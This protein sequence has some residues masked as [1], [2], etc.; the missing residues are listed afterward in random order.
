[1]QNNTGND[2][3]IY[4]QM[5]MKKGSFSQSENGDFIFDV[6]AS[7]ENLD[8]EQQKVLQEALLASKD[9]FLKNGVISKDHLHQKI[10]EDGAGK[11]I[12]FDES[13]VIG[14]PIAVYTDGGST[15][16]R[17]KLYRSNPYA[18]KFIQLLKDGSSRIKASVGGI[19][20]LVEKVKE[21]GAEIGKIVSVLWNDLALTIAPV[22]PTVSAASMV[23]SLSSLEFVK[24][25][26][27]GAGTDS[28]QYT[29]GRAMV[30]E[31]MQG[32][33]DDAAPINAFIQAVLAGKIQK[34]EDVYTFLSGFGIEGGE[35]EEA[36]RSIFNDKDIREVLPMGKV[37]LWDNMKAQLEKSFGGKK[38]DEK[39]EEEEKKKKTVE[40]SI[41]E[42][43][44]KVNDEKE[45]DDEADDE[46][47]N[48]ELK[49]AL[50][51][52]PLLESIAGELEELKNSVS[53]LSKSIASLSQDVTSV[54]EAAEKAEAQQE[55]L[56]KSLL[57]IADRVQSFGD[58]PVP[59]GAAV[60]ALEM[61]K[62]QGGD[63]AFVRHKQFTQ[64]AKKDALEVLLKAASAGE[65]SAI[66]LGKAESQ[67]N[68]SIRDPSFQ[69]DQKY[70]M[71]LQKAAAA[72]AV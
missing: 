25:L 24:S 9:Y 30:P 50:D 4:L 33:R 49:K 71:L 14:E 19:A 17:G 1:M 34:E 20:P 18:Q 60:R 39:E 38:K 28:A 68:K 11:H 53:K 67:I 12:I 47:S 56:G 35:A 51:A 3:M 52:T 61:R 36:I 32:K 40:K 54:Q 26:S 29:G 65:I 31:D 57:T 2:R 37:N 69:L 23:K 13:F 64:E 63:S 5:E 66:E 62:A 72:Q 10:V 46:I 6:E 15:R 45:N 58:T 16:V 42:D 44:Q 48:E 55:L 7:N 8:L 59:R 27:A 22:N 21:G 43:K 41:D 70:I